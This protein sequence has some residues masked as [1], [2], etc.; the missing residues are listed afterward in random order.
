MQK[1]RWAPHN[2]QVKCIARGFEEDALAFFLDPGLGKTS[3]MLA[4]FKMLKMYGIVKRM[5]VVAPIRVCYLVWPLEIQKWVNF[6]G[7]SINVLHGPSKKVS[8]ADIHVINPEGLDWLVETLGKDTPFEML[9]CDESTLFKNNKSART[10]LMKK[11]SARFERRYILT[12]TP[13]PNGYMGLFSQMYIMN[14][15]AVL[16]KRITRFRST[17]FSQ[18]GNPKHQ[19]YKIRKGEDARI[20]KRVSKNVIRLSAQDYLTL[21]KLSRNTIFVSLPKRARKIYDELEKE[22]YTEINNEEIV[23]MSPVSVGHKLRQLCGGFLY[24]DVDPLAPVPKKRQYYHIHT[25][26]IEALKKLIESNGGKPLLVAYWYKHEAEQLK[27]HF[28]NAVFVAQGA[29]EKMLLEYE[30]NWNSGRVKVM[31]VQPM[32]IAHGVNLQHA[33]GDICWYSM[34]YDFELY[35]QLVARLWRQGATKQVTNHFL[36][37]KDSIDEVILKTLKCK[38][39]QQDG[40]FK[41]LVKNQKLHLEKRVTK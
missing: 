13:V 4:L 12:G 41:Q 2:Y 24:K 21:P 34:I 10:K 37:V 27:M 26:K 31:F 22:L 19:I 25:A 28:K 20:N 18:I 1:P 32:T 35:D 15:G 33:G 5:L 8:E 36:I 39:I 16:G 6:E 23:P 38:G 11:F 3:I 40:F 9:V 17:H 7:L 30:K 14:Q 29:S